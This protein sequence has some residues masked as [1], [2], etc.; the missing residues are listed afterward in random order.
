MILTVLAFHCQPADDVL[1]V[2]V[3]LYLQQCQFPFL[4]LAFAKQLV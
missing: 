1:V 2:Q 4:S 3:V